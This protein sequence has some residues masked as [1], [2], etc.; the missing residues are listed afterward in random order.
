MESKNGQTI[1]GG[2]M[3]ES[4]HSEHKI[5]MGKI[6][7]KYLMTKRLVE[8]LDIAY[9]FNTETERTEVVLVVKE[10]ERTIPLGTLWSA[11]DF[12]LRQVNL[13]D[14]EII[15]KV[16]KLYEVEDERKTLD[17]FNNG[18]HP[19]DPNYDDIWKFIDS[20]REAVKDEL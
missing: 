17:E 16:F 2:M 5:G 14:S 18:F 7:E 19:K 6:Y 8:M 12:Q 20:A 3:D 13:I 11:E 10:G 15:S 9:A 4:Q 1:R